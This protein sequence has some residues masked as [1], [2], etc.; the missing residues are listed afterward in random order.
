[1]TERAPQALPEP[2]PIEVEPMS[3]RRGAIAGVIAVFNRNK[4][5]WIGLVLFLIIEIGRAHV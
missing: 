5:S 4:T 3:P 2:D 1:M